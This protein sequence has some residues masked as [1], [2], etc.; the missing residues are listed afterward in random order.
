MSLPDLIQHN[1][2]AGKVTLYTLAGGM[3]PHTITS[4]ALMLAWP[5]ARVAAYNNY[6]DH[7]WRLV[8]KFMLRYR[9]GA[10]ERRKT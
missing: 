3:E 10:L 7:E 9:K 4:V 8:R 1:T 6:L 2:I 5:K